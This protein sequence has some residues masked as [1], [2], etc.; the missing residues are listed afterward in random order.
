M[1]EL[2]VQMVLVKRPSDVLGELTLGIV[3]L[4]PVILA[5]VLWWSLVFTPDQPLDPLY[6]LT[7]QLVELTVVFLALVRGFRP[8]AMLG[9]F[10]Q[11]IRISIIL[12]LMVAIG[13]A[14]LNA[15]NPADALFDSTL[16]IMHL[17]FG[18]SVSWLTVNSWNLHL[19]EIWR[20]FV[21]SLLFYC[22]LVIIFVALIDNPNNFDWAR[23]GIGV[24]NVRA[25]IFYL[26]PGYFAALGLIATATSNKAYLAAVCA[27]T[28]MMALTCWSGSRSAA[29]AFVIVPAIAMMVIPGIRTLKF[30][31]A[32]IVSLAAGAALSLIHNP[33]HLAYGIFWRTA[34]VGQDVSAG[35]MEIWAHVWT[36]ILH[37]PIFGHGDQRLYVS[38][39]DLIFIHPHNS[40]L[41]IAIQWGFVGA[42]LFFGLV[43]VI[44]LG[45]LRNA[46]RDP[47]AYVP[48]F[49]VGTGLLFVSLF[50]GALFWPHPIMVAAFAAALGLAS[51]PHN[52]SV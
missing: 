27:A 51:G 2:N 35:R 9:A 38:V 28:A 49:L 46:R 8:F 48:A 21:T 26:V 32:A 52:Q 11:R 36:Q 12:L 3:L 22:L 10:D 4:L 16:W 25:I 39:P 43:G 1:R 50:D 41:Q 37:D 34:G 33:P 15:K 6:G 14:G 18:L 42:A 24:F 13:S 31:I 29:L 40:V 7:S 23:L 30:S 5:V 19:Y 45:V 44:W 17:L 20:L 47:A